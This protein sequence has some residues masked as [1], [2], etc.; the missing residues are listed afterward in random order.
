M[1]TCRD[2]FW[3]T[4]QRAAG[5]NK[6][7]QENETPAIPAHPQGHIAIHCPT[8]SLWGLPG[9]QTPPH[10][11]SALLAHVKREQSS[12]GQPA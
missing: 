8:H 11:H 7:Q 2:R 10:R 3:R 5:E 4:T 6:T 9:N 12:W 1:G